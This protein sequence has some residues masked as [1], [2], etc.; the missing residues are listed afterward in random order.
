[1]GTVGV[2]RRLLATPRFVLMWKK[3]ALFEE[4]GEEKHVH[5]LSRASATRRLK[6]TLC[7]SAA[8]KSHK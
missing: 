3:N 2:G 6:S 7:I 4:M 5:L 8:E 1:M